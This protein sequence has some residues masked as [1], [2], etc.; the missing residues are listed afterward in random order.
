MS[1]RESARPQVRAYNMHKQHHPK[2]HH[3]DRRADKIAAEAAGA[4]DDELLSTKQVAEWLCVSEQ[5][6]EIGRSKKYG[7]EFRVMGP[8]MVKY[9]R[10]DVRAWLDARKHSCTSEY[11]PARR[12]A[13]AAARAAA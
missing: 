5:W 10:G 12:K 2:R 9:Q 4:S 1:E 3:L 13:K 7:P 6:L 8:R 11:L